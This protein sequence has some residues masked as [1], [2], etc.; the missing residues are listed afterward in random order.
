MSDDR[1][2][3]GIWT[4]ASGLR[5]IAPSRRAEVEQ[6]EADE[7]EY[8]RDNPMSY[9][10]HKPHELSANDNARDAHAKDEDLPWYRADNPMG[11]FQDPGDQLEIE[12]YISWASPDNGKDD[13]IDV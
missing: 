7:K 13:D 8:A 10:A 9:H 12:H 3:Y 2:D 5:L 1:D 6:T 4:M 11:F